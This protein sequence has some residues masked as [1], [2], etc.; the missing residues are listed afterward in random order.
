MN[1]K[2][3]FLKL[4]YRQDSLFIFLFFNPSDTACHLPYIFL[5]KTQ[6]RSVVVLGILAVILVSDK[7]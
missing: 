7:G 3:N 2:Y 1:Y 6:G 4:K 5:Q